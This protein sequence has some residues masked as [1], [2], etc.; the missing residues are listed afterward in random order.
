MVVV[1]PD[2]ILVAQDVDRAVPEVE[3]NV[4]NTGRPDFS[5]SLEMLQRHGH[6]VEIAEPPA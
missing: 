5:R 3:V 2:P 1:N 4:Q 6:V